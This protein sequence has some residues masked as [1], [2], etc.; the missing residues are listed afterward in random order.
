MVRTIAGRHSVDLTVQLDGS[1]HYTTL[2]AAGTALGRS[3]AIL[4][5]LLTTRFTTSIRPQREVA[6]HG[7]IDSMPAQR[8]SN[9]AA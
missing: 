8:R 3:C 5:L 9:G 7:Q 6:V 4:M 1:S 2:Q